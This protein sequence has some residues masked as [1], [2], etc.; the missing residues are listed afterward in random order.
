MGSATGGAAD[1]DGA[2]ATSGTGVARATRTGSVGAP[3]SRKTS[4]RPRESRRTSTDTSGGTCRSTLTSEALAAISRRSSFAGVAARS[5]GSNPSDGVQ[6]KR[7]APAK[8]SPRSASMMETRATSPSRWTATR[9]GV[10]DT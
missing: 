7:R 8:R 6:E 5:A 3:A 4:S 2:A 9:P 1:R 10:P